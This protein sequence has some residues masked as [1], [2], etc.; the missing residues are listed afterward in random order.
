MPSY[1]YM[2]CTCISSDWDLF[3]SFPPGNVVLIFYE[4][5][6]LPSSFWDILDSSLTI[7]FMFLFRDIET[8]KL[9]NNYLLYDITTHFKWKVWCNILSKQLIFLKKITQ[10]LVWIGIW[11][12]VF[13]DHCCWNIEILY[14]IFCFNINWIYFYFYWIY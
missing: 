7:S 14:Q 9:L 1:I 13:S 2:F 5:T 4:S 8:L 10:V 11:K 6:E 3:L 12:I